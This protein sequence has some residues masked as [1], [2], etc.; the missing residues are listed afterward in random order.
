[1]AAKPQRFD[2]IRVT[3]VKKIEVG[4]QW[5]INLTL[6]TEVLIHNLTRAL[7]SPQEINTLDVSTVDFSQ[8]VPIQSSSLT[9]EAVTTTV[10]AQI[11]EKSST[12]PTTSANSRASFDLP[13]KVSG[14]SMYM[15]LK[16]LNTF[17]RDWKI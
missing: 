11:S 15:P 8:I 4:K 5:L 12:G 6:P 10:S 2:V 13:K 3:G 17:A 14:F 1:M 9:E 16:A 7:G